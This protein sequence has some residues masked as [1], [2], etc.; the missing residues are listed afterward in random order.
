MFPALAHYPDGEWGIG[1]DVCSWGGIQCDGSHIQGIF[2]YVFPSLTTDDCKLLPK[3][4]I[5]FLY[6]QSELNVSTI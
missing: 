6:M 1:N 3:M 2:L 4:P 5:Y